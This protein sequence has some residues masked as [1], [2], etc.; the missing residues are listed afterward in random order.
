M[1]NL[2]TFKL[3]VTCLLIAHTGPHCTA[4]RRDRSDAFIGYQEVSECKDDMGQAVCESYKDAG[5]CRTG[6]IKTSCRKS[7][8][9]C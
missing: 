6:Y 4:S 1:R 8:E 7:C 3:V 2:V 5:M 9:A